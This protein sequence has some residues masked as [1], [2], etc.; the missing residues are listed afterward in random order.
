MLEA[1]EQLIGDG[2][3]DEEVSRQARGRGDAGR[4][5]MT[6]SLDHERRIDARDSA[7]RP[8]GSADTAARSLPS[9]LF[10]SK[11]FPMATA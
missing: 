6:G 7:Q 2:G 9:K 4:H 8:S 5:D 11:R 3:C 1:R 10:Q